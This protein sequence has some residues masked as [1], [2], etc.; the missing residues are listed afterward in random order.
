MLRKAPV[1]AIALVQCTLSASIGMCFRV[2]TKMSQSDTKTIN[3]DT[4]T[5]K[6]S[7]VI[8]DYIINDARQNDERYAT[9]KK[10]LCEVRDNDVLH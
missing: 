5:N 9:P 10:R 6:Y 8:N 1:I 7:I 4:F 3:L 2:W